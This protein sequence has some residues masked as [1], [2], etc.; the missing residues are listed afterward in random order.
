M[1]RAK[2][3]KINYKVETN[4]VVAYNYLKQIMVRARKTIE[5]YIA[6]EL[7]QKQQNRCGACGDLLRRFEQTHQETVLTGWYR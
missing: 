1:L 3:V 4:N 6:A 5:T 7:M 2:G